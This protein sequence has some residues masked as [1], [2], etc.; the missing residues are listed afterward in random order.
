METKD[1]RQLGLIID[2]MVFTA[3]IA[4]IAPLE[5]V[6]DSV[7]KDTKLPE[8]MIPELFLTHNGD[9]VHA[10]LA[11][12]KLMYLWSPKTIPLNCTVTSK[13]GLVVPHLGPE[14]KKL[15]VLH[16][17]QWT[18]PIPHF[19][20]MEPTWLPEQK[21]WHM[22]DLYIFAVAKGQT[23]RP[24]LPNC[25]DDGRACHN[26]ERSAVYHA[27]C[28]EMVAWIDQ[29]MRDSVWNSHLHQ[30]A[31]SKWVSFK[32]KGEGLEQVDNP[33]LVEH[34]ESSL[35]PVSNK[36]INKVVE[37]WLQLNPAKS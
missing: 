30:V 22:T 8:V 9:P 34:P 14:D 11:L 15:N 1:I 26:T 6:L 24:P 23:W 19:Y 3:N 10:V 13:D 28:V 2:G 37:L 36:T 4:G 7:P 27:N 12:G 5:K 32:P 18:P 29:H 25:F 35:S 16:C 33:D 21:K 17:L 20:L 31:I